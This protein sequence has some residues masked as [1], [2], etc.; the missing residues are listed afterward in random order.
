M[1]FYT[2]V[3]VSSIILALITS[4][5]SESPSNFNISSD[6]PESGITL[7]E[8]SS[9]V[10]Q[11]NIT[12]DNVEPSYVYSFTLVS[13]DEVIA[14]TSEAVSLPGDECIKLNEED[15]T[16]YWTSN[17]T[18]NGH[19]LGRTTL[20]PHIAVP[21]T[22]S[23]NLSDDPKYDY[24]TPQDDA[25]YPVA[26]FRVLGPKDIIFKVIVALSV[27]INFIGFGCKFDRDEA[28]DLLHRP[29]PI[30][31]GSGLLFTLMPLVTY[32]RTP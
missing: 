14:T 22:F 6:V 30:I 19:R 32:L 5:I 9:S 26:V 8:G 31:L 13:A 17:Y 11:F 20:K 3:L 10:F 7:D 12:T 24:G 4:V 21:A 2:V 23:Q 27:V 16:C 28:K 15:T 1:D 25:I 29:F 18:V